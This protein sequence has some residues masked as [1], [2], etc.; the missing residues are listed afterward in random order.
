MLGTPELDVVHEMV[1]H[2]RGV[3]VYSINAFLFNGKIQAYFLFM[4]YRLIR[5]THSV[6]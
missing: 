6:F 2:E 4:A 3:E 5:K 1:S